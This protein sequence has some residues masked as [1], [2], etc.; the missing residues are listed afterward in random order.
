LKQLFRGNQGFFGNSFKYSCKYKTRRGFTL[1]AKSERPKITYAIV[2]WMAINIVLMILMITGGDYKDLNNWLEI[3]FWS[4]S[5]AGLLVWRKWGVAFALF[6][7]I[8][9]FSTSMGILIYYQVWLNAAR[10]I[11]N[12]AIIIYLFKMVFEGKIKK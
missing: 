9:T 12:G 8:Y 6:V 4:L 5:I 10:V 1:T 2:G 3:A 7:L 11:I